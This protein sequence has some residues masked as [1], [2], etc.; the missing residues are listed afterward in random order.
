MYNKETISTFLKKLRKEK[1]FTPEQ[2]VEMLNLYG[3]NIAASTLRGYENNNPKAMPNADIF[4]ALCDIYECHNPIVEIESICHREEG[5][6]ALQ[7]YVGYIDA[8][9]N[10]SFTKKDQSVIESYSGLSEQGKD[11]VREY[12]EDILIKYAAD[13]NNPDVPG[14]INETNI[15]PIEE[16][17]K[18]SEASSDEEQ[19]NL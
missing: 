18:C 14:Y 2:V 17:A 8:Y 13:K 11:K 12:I 9:Y 3:F 4:L 6:R 7:R 10:A 16:T 19:E 15:E 5:L 1:H